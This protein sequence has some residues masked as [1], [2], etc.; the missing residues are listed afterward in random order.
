MSAFIHRGVVEGFYGPPYAHVDRLWLIDRLG[1]WGMNRYV[2]AP[3]DDPL[4]RAQWRDPYPPDALREFAELIERGRAA[5]VEVGFAVSPG[6]T[7]EYASADDV[8]AL[9]AKFRGFQALGARFVS[10]ALDDVPT[11]L[12]HTGDQARFGSL[13]E[14][15]VAVAHAVA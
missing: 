1:T 7:I 8:R 6:L 4:H 9:Q 13:A 5:G 15:H 14:A 3:K 10:L 11:T 12:L 2:Y